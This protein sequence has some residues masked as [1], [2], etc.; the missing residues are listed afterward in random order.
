M[1]HKTQFERLKAMNLEDMAKHISNICREAK[2]TQPK[3]LMC[4]DWSNNCYLCLKCY[5][6]S[7]VKDV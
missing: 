5:L 7:E 4:I 3:A 2:K 6:E 1:E